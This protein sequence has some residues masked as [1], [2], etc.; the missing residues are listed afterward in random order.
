[1]RA[2]SVGTICVFLAL[3]AGSRAISV[4]KREPRCEIYCE[5]PAVFCDPCGCAAAKSECPPWNGAA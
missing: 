1:M 2:S 3:L 4:N 5:P